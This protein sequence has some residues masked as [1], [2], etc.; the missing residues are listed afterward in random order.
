M[1]KRRFLVLGIMI[2]VAFLFWYSSLIQNT[3]YLIVDFF[4]KIVLYNN[5][6][7]IILFIFISS[8]AALISP[9]TNIPLV[10]VAVVVWGPFYTTVILLIGWVIGD[11]IAYFIG[12]YLGY[13]VILYLGS[14][15]KFNELEKVIKEH[16]NFYTAL[17]LRLTLPAELGYIFGII[18]YPFNLYL[19]ITFLAELPFAIISTTLSEAVLFG[20]TIK[21]FSFMGILLVI[22]F[23]IFEFIHKKH[24]K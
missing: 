23:L 19:I 4:N 2:I 17:L 1:N 20:N 9:F 22:L 16:T 11:I 7:A 8:L 10:P 6:L 12:K 5:S 21:F 18:R 3:F 24:A 14:K 13:P 15:E